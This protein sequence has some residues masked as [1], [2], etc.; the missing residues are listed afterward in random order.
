MPDYTYEGTGVHVDGVTNGKPANKAGVEKGDVI[1]ALG[2][3]PVANLKDYMKALAKFK[4][5]DS[6]N[7]KVKRNNEEKTFNLTF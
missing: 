6:T 3:N 2:D 4:K 5:G 1:V 7:V